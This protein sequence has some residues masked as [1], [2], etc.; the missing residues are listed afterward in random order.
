MAKEG[1][2]NL[3]I[4]R[5]GKELALEVPV[6]SRRDTLIKGLGGKYPSY[7]VYGPLV[8]S[9]VTAEFT[10]LF[11]RQ[12]GAYTALLLMGS[13]LALRR[14]DVPKFPGEELVVVASPLFPHKIAKGYSNPITKV[15][16]SING[17]PIKSL[18]HL[19]ETLRDSKDQYI[20]IDFDD[21]ASENMVFDRKEIMAATE[22]IL[23]DNGVRKPMS[24][25][26]VKYWD[27]D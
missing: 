22:D 25:D 23:T 16:K 10:S 21:K 26:L 27:K 15:I 14:A 7:F 3:T 20:I 9:P 17:I 11:D 6:R 19:V 24:D 18:K 5:D 1:K 12:P 8:F 2:L 13:P 4:I